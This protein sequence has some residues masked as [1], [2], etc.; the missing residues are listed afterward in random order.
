MLE[1]LL[2]PL[3]NFRHSDDIARHR[4]ACRREQLPFWPDKSA[5]CCRIKWPQLYRDN[6]GTVGKQLTVGK[7]KLQV[8][9]G[10]PQDVWAPVLS[11]TDREKNMFDVMLHHIPFANGLPLVVVPCSGHKYWYSHPWR[12]PITYKRAKEGYQWHGITASNYG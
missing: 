4:S 8:S 12:A 5:T 2:E 9:T 3:C 7:L 11:G 6:T 10:F 1:P